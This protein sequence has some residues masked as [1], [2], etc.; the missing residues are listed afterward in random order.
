MDSQQTNTLARWGEVIQ[1][2]EHT[3]E[4]GYE[5]VVDTV[6]MDGVA[7]NFVGVKYISSHNS[8]RMSEGCQ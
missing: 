5:I 6:V 7:M 2:Q 1:K 4:K 3:L 8:S